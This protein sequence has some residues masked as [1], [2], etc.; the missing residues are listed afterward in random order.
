MVRYKSFCGATL[1]ALA[2]FSIS[3]A[4]GQNQISDQNESSPG[5]PL[6]VEVISG[7]S[8]LPDQTD[9]VELLFVENLVDPSSS[10]EMASDDEGTAEYEIYCSPP[11][12]LSGGIVISIT[13]Q[14]DTGA[15]ASHWKIDLFEWVLLTTW[16]TVGDLTGANSSEFN[17]VDLVLV[18]DT[19]RNFAE[20]SNS[21]FL[22]RLYTSGASGSEVII[23]DA[24]SISAEAIRGSPLFVDMIYGAAILPEQ[25]DGEELEFIEGAVDSASSV[26]MASNTEGF[27]EYEIYFTPPS[28][29]VGD[30]IVSI[31]VQLGADASASHW[32]VDL[33][34]WIVTNTWTSVGDL[35][36]ATSSAFTTVDLVLE[37]VTPN[38][39][40]EPNN[41][42]FLVRVYTIDASGVEV[43]V[44]DA[45][46]IAAGTAFT[47][48][49]STVVSSAPPQPEP[50]APPSSDPN[51][52]ANQ[53]TVAVS[54]SES[55]EER[56]S[57]WSERGWEIF[58]GIAS[59]VAAAGV[60]AVVGWFLQKRNISANRPIEERVVRRTTYD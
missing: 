6:F 25:N 3:R 13:V 55:D 19:P 46:S 49:S 27:A 50:T 53:P 42:E 57:T 26:E 15:N 58:V 32:R 37:T 45:V 9:G 34:E 31:T 39:F 52:E 40:A 7:A 43:I 14:L 24:V 17:T 47:S 20:P 12:P 22:V 1:V 60:L 4:S 38:Y 44:L 36:G 23:V 30:I 28:P 16:V 35:T 5:V 56:N 59:T 54:N 48:P 18:T 11:S 51:S 10:V 41:S 2:C 8:I 33:F 29:L 21:E